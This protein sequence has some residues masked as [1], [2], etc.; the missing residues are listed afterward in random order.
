MISWI[1]YKHKI[2]GPKLKQNNEFTVKEVA[3]KFDVSTYMV[4]YWIE[5]KYVNARRIKQGY[6]YWISLNSKKEKELRE[7]INKSYKY[8]SFKEETER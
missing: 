5:R 8:V 7:R 2:P 4:Y 1:K 6:P 3:K